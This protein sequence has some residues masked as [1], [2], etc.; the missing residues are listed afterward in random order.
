MSTFNMQLQHIKK[1]KHFQEKQKNKMFR[2]SQSH[3][4]SCSKVFQNHHADVVDLIMRIN[5]K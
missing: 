5:P 3:L 2:M 1:K 4:T